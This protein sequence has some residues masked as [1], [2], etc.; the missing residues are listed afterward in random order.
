MS[1]VSSPARVRAPRFTGAVEKARLSLVPAR[2]VSAPRAPF[3]VLVFAIL[4]SGVVGLLMF[5]T[6]MQQASFRATELQNQAD[7]LTARQQQL[8]ME[9]DRLR[10]P[11][12]LAAAAQNL[13]MVPPGI[14]AFV[15]LGDRKV[16]GTPTAAKS[17]DSMRIYPLPSRLPAPLRPDPI[18]VRVP[19]KP[20][21]QAA[22]GQTG[23]AT[24]RASTAEAT[25]TGRNEGTAADQGASR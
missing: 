12:R 21:G 8:D 16:I 15:E 2:R 23:S 4:V 25:G 17:G 24:G 22:S 6:H 7:D 9:L 19:A 20:G 14:P 3:A 10:D 11:Q 1:I 18:I 5:N 13:G